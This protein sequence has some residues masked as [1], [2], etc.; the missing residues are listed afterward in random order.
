MKLNSSKTK[1]MIVYRSRIMHPKSPPLIIGGTVLKESDDLD[2][3]GV[4]FDS[5]M[6]FATN[7]FSVSRTD[8]QIL[9]ILRRPCRVFH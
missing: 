9:G 6:T 2:I 5:E 4:I 1:T 7:P 8:N 3:L